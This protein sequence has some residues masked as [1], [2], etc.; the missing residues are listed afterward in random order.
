MAVRGKKNRRFSVGATFEGGT[1]L[2][3]EQVRRL[4]C[5]LGQ[6]HSLSG[7]TV[8]IESEHPKGRFESSRS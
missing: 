3:E 5:Q 7:Y 4:I 6:S 2:K 1:R 8:V